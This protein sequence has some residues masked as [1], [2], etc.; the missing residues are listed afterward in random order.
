MF[1]ADF[2]FEV[3]WE[4]CNKVG[5]IHTVLESLSPT[6]HSKFGDRVAFLGPD[7]GTQEFDEDPSLNPDWQAAAAS[8]GLKI[9]IGRWN[10]ASKPI[11]VLV[12]VQQFY[13][14]KNEIYA[15][16]WNDFK[17]DSLNAYGDYDDSSMWAYACGK[18][19]R[20]ITRRCIDVEKN[21]VLQAHEWQSAMALL[22][23]AKDLPRRVAT[24]FT[25]HA[26]TVG[27]SIC[28]NG[29]CLY[30]YFGEYDGDIMARELNVMAKHSSE[31]AAAF[32]AG[33]FTT[34]SATTNEE[35]RQLL[36][37]ETD[38]LLP[39]GFETSSI[40]APRVLDARRSAMRAKVLSV[41]GALLGRRFD[42]RNTLIVSTSGRND[43]KPKG[44]DV[45]FEALRRLQK[46]GELECEVVALAEVPCWIAG[47]RE[48]LLQRL[49]NKGCSAGALEYPFITHRL[50]NFDYDRIV[51]TIRSMQLDSLTLEGN[52]HVL[53]VPS[54]LDGR[55]GI[56]NE[57]YYS[58]L[59]A[60][61]LTAY[62]SYYEPW[63][64]TPMESASYSIPTVTTSLA[65]FGCWVE[66]LLKHKPAI[67]DG[68][69]VM[70]RNDE[71]YFETAEELKRIIL[72]FSRR[73]RTERKRLGT[74]ARR[75]AQNAD[76][77]LF[78]ENYTK[79]F[80]F[81]IDKIKN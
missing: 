74:K 56:F 32:N 79:A 61:D 81:A 20:A 77:R 39:N 16:M 22:C 60:C 12:D 21:V 28:D 35:C 46:C 8:E 11:A 33:C 3:S 75:I 26:T 30:K 65:G 34:V 1:E 49:A 17:V 72:D 18:V 73:N 66:E 25:T 42:D 71:N 55:D 23:V 63:G 58:L 54:Y 2:V 15:A 14:R 40:P 24:V 27:R 52:V 51:G 6:L 50:H 41:A 78:V 10:I 5:G 7:L 59:T 44:Y 19:V 67:S 76:W 48:D 80:A 68:I 31:K 53:L 37:K 57:H 13:D 64:Y 45:Y 9:R 69:A 62:P 47:P 43:Y 38:V 70:E 36:G 29:K 4:V